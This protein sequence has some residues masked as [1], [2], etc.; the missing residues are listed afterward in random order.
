MAKIDE[1]L[2]AANSRALSLPWPGTADARATFTRT[3]PQTADDQ[4]HAR[5]VYRSR[6]KRALDLVIILLAAPFVL[7]LVAI[8]ALVVMTDGGSPFYRQARVGRGGR[9]FRMW[10]LRSMAIDADARLEEVLAS[11]P[12]LRRE[13]D[14]SQKLRHDPRITPIGRIIRKTSIDEL[15]QLMNVIAGDMSIVGPRPM[16]PDQQDMYDGE[17]YYRLRPGLT[18]MWQVS[19]RNLTS[20]ADRANFDSDY[21]SR[22]SFWT[23]FKL[24]LATVRAV[25]RGTGC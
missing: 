8:C 20:F 22:L 9:I 7:P 21:D 15:P 2:P 6:G 14:H 13:W 3:D 11:D 16:M 19:E 1:I 25:L 24:L 23:D 4:A 17:S 10:K 12:E 18:G 5:G